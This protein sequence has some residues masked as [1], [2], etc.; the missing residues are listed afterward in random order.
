MSL[1]RRDYPS[2]YVFVNLRTRNTSL[3]LFVKTP[4][5]STSHI[6]VEI[7][8]CTNVAFLE[9]H[10]NNSGTMIRRSSQRPLSNNTKYSQETHI[11]APDGIRTH[12]PSKRAVADPCLRPRGHWDRQMY[13]IPN[14]IVEPLT[15]LLTYS[16][17]QSPSREANWFCS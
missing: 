14:F 9:Q 1:G 10:S 2:V 5:S 7:V 4:C 3:T 11:R 17:E 8:G 15:Y 6:Y 13:C 12:N 16:M